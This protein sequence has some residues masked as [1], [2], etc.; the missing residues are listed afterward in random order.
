MPPFSLPDIFISIIAAILFADAAHTHAFTTIYFT[1]RHA[2]IPFH[3]FFFLCFCA[4]HAA[5]AYAIDADARFS[6]SA[7]AAML[8]YAP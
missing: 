5:Y 2:A 6:L 7:H 3:A 8:I 4:L 1:L